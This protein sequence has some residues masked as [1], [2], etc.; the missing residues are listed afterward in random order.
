MRCFSVIAVEKLHGDEGLAIFFANV[1]NGAD[2]GMIQRGRRL[3][4]AL[5]T[6]QRLRIASDFVWQ[7]FEGDKPVQA[8]VFGLV[9]NA[10][11]TTAQLLD[12][13]V[14]R[15]GLADHIGPSIVGPSIVW[16]STEDAGLLSRFILRMVAS[17]RQR[18]R[19]GIGDGGIRESIL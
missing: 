12:D 5:K 3:R 14:V 8:R 18:M 6:S 15:D 9:H 2:V 11:A 16:P 4:L 10:H 7:E 17:T 19:G 1:V 13:A